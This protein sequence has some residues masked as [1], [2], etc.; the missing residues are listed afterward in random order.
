MAAFYYLLVSII[1]VDRRERLLSMA[2]APTLAA[3][4]RGKGVAGGGLHIAYK[5]G[6]S[7]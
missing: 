6:V 4:G 7:T 3:G 1:S 2:L 5:P